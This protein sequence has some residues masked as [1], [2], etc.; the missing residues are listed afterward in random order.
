MSVPRPA[1]GRAPRKSDDERATD[2]E[3][4]SIDDGPA[5]EVRA[6]VASAARTPTS[7]VVRES[8]Q[9]ERHE[10]VMGL[11]QSV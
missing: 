10:V 7:S 4:A 2:P 5:G 11:K 9:R 3:G 8:V 1:M 6:S